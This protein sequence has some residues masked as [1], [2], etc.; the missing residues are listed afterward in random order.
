MPHQNRNWQRAGQL[1][2]KRKRRLMKMVGFLNLQKFQTAY[3]MVG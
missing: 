2:L 3:L 1:I